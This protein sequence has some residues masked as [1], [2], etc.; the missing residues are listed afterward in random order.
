MCAYV[1]R[2]GVEQARRLSHEVPRVREER[3]G[4]ARLQ[5]GELPAV[6]VAVSPTL[7][8]VCPIRVA[9][10][11]VSAYQP[12]GADWHAMRAAGIR[13]MFGRATVGLAVDSSFSKHVAAARAADVLAGGYH[14]FQANFDINA[15][16]D[17][18]LKTN[19]TVTL[20]LPPMIDIEILA[21]VAPQLVHERVVSF[22]ER[23]RASSGRV[24][25]IYTGAGFWSELGSPALSPLGT[26]PL[27]DAMYPRAHRA[28]DTCGRV[29]DLP[30]AWSSWLGWQ[31]SGDDGER[32]DGMTGPVDRDWFNGSFDELRAWA[33][34]DIVPAKAQ[35]TIVVITM[36]DVVS[37]LKSA[38][39]NPA[40]GLEA[41]LR[42]FQA[43]RKIP[44][45]GAPDRMTRAALSASLTDPS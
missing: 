27:F 36:T 6:I 20:D 34:S 33:A 14:F 29:P 13:W 3:R 45:T 44:A 11:D 15:A 32:V 31:Y 1:H 35:P 21:G 25:I 12:I 8:A 17:L 39:F 26:Y 40:D 28:A 38:G 16:A 10:V 30:P 24:P 22:A 5:V 18:Y 7:D 2:S 19:E 42:G 23:V 9:G 41:A 37:T 4:C 43:S